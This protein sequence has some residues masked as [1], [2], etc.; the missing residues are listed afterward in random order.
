MRLIKHFKCSKL[1]KIYL[2]ANYNTN[3]GSYYKVNQY[4]QG[5]W[6]LFNIFKVH[7]IPF[8]FMFIWLDLILIWI[9]VSEN[10]HF[11]FAFRCNCVAEHKTVLKTKLFKMHVSW[12]L[13]ICLCCVFIYLH[14]IITCHLINTVFS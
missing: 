14:R 6:V 3:I 5:I 9:N 10:M 7:F 4:I 12:I 13:Y 1:S 8:I 11:V 2:E